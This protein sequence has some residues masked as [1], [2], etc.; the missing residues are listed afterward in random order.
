MHGS[1]WDRYPLHL[2]RAMCAAPARWARHSASAARPSSSH[3]PGPSSRPSRCGAGVSEN[4]GKQ[5]GKRDAG[6]KH[7]LGEGKERRPLLF[8]LQKHLALRHRVVEAHRRQV[9]RCGEESVSRT[10]LPA[11]NTPTCARKGIL[12]A[13]QERRD[14]V[15]EAR[16]AQVS[17][18]RHAL[19]AEVLLV[20]R[21]PGR[22]HGPAMRG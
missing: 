17:V 16:R 19:Q 7:S 21:R 4:C 2:Y 13:G 10:S 6:G 11:R 22:Q 15:D 9:L 8:H 14:K 12:V 18:P 3:V 5:G 1:P 20:K